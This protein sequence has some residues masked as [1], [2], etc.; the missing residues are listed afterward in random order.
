MTV[1]EPLS[2]IQSVIFENRLLEAG[3]EGAEFIN[4]V[5]PSDKDLI[6]PPR[7]GFSSYWANTIQS[8]LEN[9]GVKTLLIAGMLAEGCVES[10]SRDAVEIGILVNENT[11]RRLMTS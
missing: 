10:H 8:R 3:T 5:A 4:E 11:I 6:L 7:Q 1:F 9:L 2:S